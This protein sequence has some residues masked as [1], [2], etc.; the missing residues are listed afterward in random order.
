MI[1]NLEFVYSTCNVGCIISKLFGN[2]Y[3]HVHITK[4]KDLLDKK[5]KKHYITE[6]GNSEFELSKLY[7][8]LTKDLYINDFTIY[9]DNIII[10]ESEQ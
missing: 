4:T 3:K 9:D 10:Y 2:K 1:V 6:D 7:Q 8:I 5:R